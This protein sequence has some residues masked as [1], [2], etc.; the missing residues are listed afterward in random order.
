VGIYGVLAYAVEQRT[1]ELGV[2][3]AIGAQRRDVLRMVLG[4]GGRTVALGLALGLG[5]ALALGGFLNAHLFGV[6]RFDPVTFLL[7]V[8]VLGTVAVVACLLPALRAARVDPIVALR[9]E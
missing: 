7:V 8:G 4:Q 9:H 3:L 5:G 1:G 2:R 6:S